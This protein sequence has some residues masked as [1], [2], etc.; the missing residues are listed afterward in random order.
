MY[1]L[2]LETPI[3]CVRDTIEEDCRDIV[4]TFDAVLED[5]L[6][7]L[8]KVRCPDGS[9]IFYIRKGHFITRNNSSVRWFVVACECGKHQA[10]LYIDCLRS[11]ELR[12][13]DLPGWSIKP[14]GIPPQKDEMKG[15]DLVFIATIGISHLFFSSMNL[16]LHCKEKTLPFKISM[17]QKKTLLRIT[18]RPDTAN[19][20]P[21][22]AQLFYLQTQPEF[23]VFR[24]IGQ[25]EE[26]ICEFGNIKK[27]TKYYLHFLADRS[28]IYTQKE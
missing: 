16:Q 9:R 6:K 4:S 1:G 25:S 22:F 15:M 17:D 2:S 23:A 24:S 11:G 21:R 10:H 13:P 26:Y 18:F 7:Y 14:A 5:Q 3:R 12:P 8:A 28:S 27:K 20:L 19:P